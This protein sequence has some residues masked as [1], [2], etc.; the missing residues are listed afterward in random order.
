M[1]GRRR[2]KAARH[3]RYWPGTPDRRQHVRV[4]PAAVDSGRVD[5]TL[6]L[7]DTINAY[8][9]PLYSPDPAVIEYYSEIFEGLNCL[10]WESMRAARFTRA[11][12]W[13]RSAEWNGFPCSLQMLPGA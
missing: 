9:M 8:Y 2:R 13:Q 1:G 12:Q 3:N 6:T 4:R 7:S 10:Q 5:E 11:A